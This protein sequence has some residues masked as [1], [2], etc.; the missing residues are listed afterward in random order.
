MAQKFNEFYVN[1]GNMVETKIPQAK[2]KFSDFL[3]NSVSNSIFLSPVDD[4]EISDMFSK[5]DSSKSC[6]S[7]S[8]SS[9]LLKNH[10]KAFFHQLKI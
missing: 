9:N 7:K 8:T 4:I 3:K 2:A 5:I 6:G 1:I 10:A